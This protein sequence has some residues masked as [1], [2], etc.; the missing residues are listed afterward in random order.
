MAKVTVGEF[1]RQRGEIVNEIANRGLSLPTNADVDRIQAKRYPL[2]RYL[3][4]QVA[5]QKTA[6]MPVRDSMPP[7]SRRTVAMTVQQRSPYVFRRRSFLSKI[8]PANFSKRGQVITGVV[9]G[10]A[11][12]ALRHAA[13]TKKA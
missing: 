3:I 13:L 7:P 9:V 6:I 11:F 8:N 1:W 10:T 2:S 12:G 4:K 5:N